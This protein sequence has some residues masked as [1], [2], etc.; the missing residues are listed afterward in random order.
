MLFPGNFF[1][2]MDAIA[3]PVNQGNGDEN[4][5]LFVDFRTGFGINFFAA[6]H[7]PIR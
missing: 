3:R 7:K 4:E 1:V 2:R 5:Q 6:R